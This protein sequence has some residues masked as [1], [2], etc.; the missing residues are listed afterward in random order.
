MGAT[1]HEGPEDGT[2]GASVAYYSIDQRSK[3]KP[4]MLSRK[5]G[6]LRFFWLSISPDFLTFDF[7]D[8]TAA[9]KLRSAEHSSTRIINSGRAR[10]LT[11]LKLFSTPAKPSFLAVEPLRETRT[12]ARGS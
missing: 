7:I 1:A 9:I 8:I 11:I 12:F 2:R 6:L 3:V 4:V 10:P 5:N